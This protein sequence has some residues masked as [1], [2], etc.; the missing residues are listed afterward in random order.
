MAS[1]EE[2]NKNAKPAV[3]AVPEDLWFSRGGFGSNARWFAVSTVAHVLLLSVSATTAVTVMQKSQELIKVAALPAS[4]DPAQQ[5]E[6]QKTPDD[7]EG[8]PSLKDLPGALSME[9]LPH[10]KVKNWSAGPAPLA[11]R[12]QA[13][14]PTALPIISSAFSPVTIQVGRTSDDLKGVTTQI[15]NLSGS[16]NGVAGGGFGDH[17]G[18]L[19]RVGI[20]VVLIVDATSNAPPHQNLDSWGASPG[21]MRW[22]RP[23]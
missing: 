3:V 7:W 13:I 14:R 11:G 2:E 15:T 16:L 23:P 1:A 10:K 4:Q 5:A 20:D 17:V 6:E 21:A 9:M 8:E 12:V 22:A 19:R 18:G